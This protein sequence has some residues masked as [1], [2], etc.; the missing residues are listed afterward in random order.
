MLGHRFAD[1]AVAF[2][3]GNADFGTVVYNFGSA[4]VIFVV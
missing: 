1:A 2:W 3:F 4:D